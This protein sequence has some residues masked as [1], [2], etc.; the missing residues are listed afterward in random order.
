MPKAGLAR[1]QDSKG[2]EER[3]EGRGVSGF[4]GRS[5]T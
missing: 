3:N 1:S 5:G 2:A 4:G